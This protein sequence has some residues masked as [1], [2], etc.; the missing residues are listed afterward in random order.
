MQMTVDVKSRPSWRLSCHTLQW[1][2]SG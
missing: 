2:H 1:M